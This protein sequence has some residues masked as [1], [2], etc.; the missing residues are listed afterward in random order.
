MLAPSQVAIYGRSYC[1]AAH[2]TWELFAF[3]GLEAAVNDSLVG[4]V[5]G[6]GAFATALVCAAAAYAYAAAS[7]TVAKDAG[8]LAAVALFAALIGLW[9]FLVVV[10][11]IASGVA[12]TYV[13]LA[14]DPATLQCQQPELFARIQESWPDITWGLDSAAAPPPPQQQPQP[15]YGASYA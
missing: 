4:N 14:E 8:H 12:A 15:P 7:Q 2:R 1:D 10:E 9:S 13:C 3:R 11:P 6:C 5:L